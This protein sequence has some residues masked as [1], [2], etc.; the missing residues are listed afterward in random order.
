M[1]FGRKKKK[2]RG[3]VSK[4]VENREKEDTAEEEDEDDEDVSK[5]KLESDDDDDVRKFWH[6]H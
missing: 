6:F 2:F 4:V 5:Y 3:Q 1:Q